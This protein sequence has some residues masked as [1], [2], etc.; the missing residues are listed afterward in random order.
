MDRL[1]PAG[2]AVEFLTILVLVVAL[3]A[4]ARD[5]QRSTRLLALWLSGAMLAEAVARVLLL[6]S[7]GGLDGVFFVHGSLHALGPVLVLMGVYGRRANQPQNGVP[8]FLGVL[9]VGWLGLGMEAGWSALWV[10]VPLHM[11]R[12][13]VFAAASVLIWRRL[14]PAFGVTAGVAAALGLVSLLTAAA[15]LMEDATLVGVAGRANWLLFVAL[16]VSVLAAMAA[17]G[18]DRRQPGLSDDGSGPA[19][20]PNRLLADLDVAIV[21]LSSDDQVIWANAGAR[22]MFHAG[23][24]SEL[25]GLPW[26]RLEPA[27]SGRRQPGGPEAGR[28]S[29]RFAGDGGHNRPVL[30]V[31]RTMDGSE[32]RLE[33]TCLTGPDA[34]GAV[35]LKL[36]DR[37]LIEH[38]SV[39]ARL[40]IEMDDLMLAGG[41]PRALG[42]LVCQRVLEMEGAALVWA[43]MRD[44]FDVLVLVAAEGDG[45]QA[46]ERAQAEPLSAAI[47]GTL[48]DVLQHGQQTLRADA[49]SQVPGVPVAFPDGILDPD[50]GADHGPALAFAFEGPRNRFGVLVVHGP[51]MGLDRN[52]RMRL[53]VV[54]R[55]LSNMARLCHE[56]G[57]LRLQSAAMSVAANAIF[58][59]EQDGRIAWANEAF[60]RLSGFSSDEVRGKTP[61]ILF[62]GHQNAD[63]YADLWSTIRRGDVWRG[64]LVERRKDGTLYTVQ[65]TITPMRSPDNDAVY[66]VAVHE[67]I[68]ARKRAEER[69][70]YLS[71]YDMLTRLPNRILFRDRLH[72]AVSLARR[73]NGHVAVLFMDLT[74]FSRVNDTLGHDIGDQ[75]L[76]TIGSRI[77]AA[78][79][80]EVDTFARMGGD[81][82]AIIQSGAQGAEAAASLAVRLSRIV[83]TPVELAGNSVSLR[84]TV[85]IALYPEDGTDPDNLIKA[86]DLAMHRVARSEGEAYRFFS[87]EINDEAQIRLDL[88]ADLRRALER[89]ELINHYQP[90]YDL[91]GRLV[92]ME[93]LVRWHHPAKGLVPPGQF[94]AVAEDS[95]LIM[96]LGEGVLQRALADLAAWKADGLPTVPV[97]VN[98]SAVQLRDSGLVTRLR[99]ALEQHGLPAS[100]LD[101]ELTESVLMGEHAGAVGFLTRLADAGFRIAIDDF[102][103]GYSSLSYL[104]RFPVH[105]LKI[106]Q[107]FVRHIN[108]DRNDTILVSAIINLG[109]SLGM[110]V[111]AEGVETEDQ[112]AHLSEVGVDVVQ[113]YL[114]GRPMPVEEMRALMSTPPLDLPGGSAS[115]QETTPS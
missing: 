82:F 108:E 98:V 16:A 27:M 10:D 81:E 115:D 45:A 75:I 100:A 114:L 94:I 40:S 52:A 24:D 18:A 104:K 9:V 4:V 29:A 7:G 110:E 51:G 71:N 37:A 39:M 53:D 85:G 88:E 43:A 49:V 69:I 113:G 36:V 84:A 103:T 97:A 93:A 3:L 109:H 41:S 57:F 87:N 13:G 11:V 111:V 76:M 42:R 86:A 55:R 33:A 21:R 28:A 79:A 2:V 112:L 68:S 62:S 47:Q 19:E 44:P 105:K 56:T 58:I 32:I 20:D 30:L 78:V 25:I 101:L 12:A 99:E 54:A 6:R 89:G 26:S 74:Q 107:S 92:G 77:N 17:E 90:Q 64:E 22:H 102:G 61:H 106:D 48:E 91:S 46:L 15:G 80:D 50:S 60:T 67:D 34:S 31:G 38:L 59:T 5:R 23:S 65:Q 83:E 95:G 72:Q 63:T 96:P 73:V 35:T 70:R 66:Y 1:I 8:L 14:G